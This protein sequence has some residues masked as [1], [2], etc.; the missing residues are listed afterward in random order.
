[1][2][3]VTGPDRGAERTPTRGTW[4]CC[5]RPGLVDQTDGHGPESGVG[6]EPVDGRGQ[7]DG[8][9]QLGVVV[10]EEEEP[11][12]DRGGAELR[13]RDPEVLGQHDQAVGGQ[14]A[15]ARPGSPRR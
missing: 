14:A 2:K 7:H 11:G 9:G 4:R 5:D 8:S 12:V 10:E 6:V 3:C 1:M 13:R 15:A